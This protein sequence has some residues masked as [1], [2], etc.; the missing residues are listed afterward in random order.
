MIAM[1]HLTNALY[2]VWLGLVLPATVFAWVTA[3]RCRAAEAVPQA[4]ALH[5]RQEPEGSSSS[6]NPR[7]KKNSETQEP[8]PAILPGNGRHVLFV[9]DERQFAEGG[10]ATLQ[11]LGYRVIL[12]ADANEALA[13]IRN[14]SVKIDRVVTDLALPGRSGFDLARLCQRLLPGVRVILMSRQDNPIAAELLLAGGIHG[15]LAKPFT[16][17]SLAEAIQRALT[18]GNDLD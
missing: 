7:A 18:G 13:A 17:Q 4:V 1:L 12:A 5:R 11:R 6:P 15:A 9:D 3:T 2:L 8:A 16:R 14:A 10:Q